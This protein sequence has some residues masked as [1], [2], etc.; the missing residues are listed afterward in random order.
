MREDLLHFVWKYK[1]IQQKKLITTQGSTIDVVAVGTHNKLAGPDFFNAQVRIN[2]QLW[3]GNVEIHVKSSDWY[4]HGHETDENYN[5]VILHVVWEDDVEIFRKDNSQIPTLALSAYISHALLSDYK[6]LFANQGIK[7]V[8]CDAQIKDV[9]SFLIDNWIERLYFER[10]ERKSVLINNLLLDSKNNWE[11]TLF[12]LLLKNFGLKI[13]GAS[14]LSLGKSLDFAVV[15]KVWNNEFQFESLLYGMLGLLEKEEVTDSYFRALK[16][17]FSFLKSKFELESEPI[18]KPHFFK[19]RPSNFPTIRLSQL[20][21]VYTKNQNLFSAIIKA[22]TLDEL[23]GVFDVAASQYWNT[24]YN[25]G[26][27]SKQRIK[28]LTKKFID[29]L[30]INTILPLKF[31]YAKYLGKEINEELITIVLGLK[32]EENTIVSNFGVLGV[33]AKNAMESQGVIELHNEYCS[34]NKCLECSIGT[35]LLSQNN[36]L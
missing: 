26:K 13:N 34:K 5:N 2:N 33:L 35:R 36:Y 3:A 24:H 18:E 10:L 19:L 22:K 9:D 11:Q 23:Y 31:S 7:F 30:V 20:S 25:F 17:E 27:T 1:K 32:K 6:N 12:V 21:Q 28:K 14:F 8:H 15:R 29:L 16:K 4:A